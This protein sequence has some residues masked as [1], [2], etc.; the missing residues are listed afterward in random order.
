MGL[1]EVQVDDALPR[2]RRARPSDRNDPVPGS[3]RASRSH[4]S[5]TITDTAPR[6]SPSF[7]CRPLLDNGLDSYYSQSSTAAIVKRG[8]RSESWLFW[9][10][11]KPTAK[12]AGHQ[13]ASSTPP[14]PTNLPKG[15]DLPRRSTP[16]TIAVHS[17][18]CPSNDPTEITHGH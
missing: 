2:Q 4:S 13:Q 1:C 17:G 7:C 10:C 15:H 11:R 8:I 5:H 9:P 12:L 6:Q 14:L 16:P 18:G 3:V